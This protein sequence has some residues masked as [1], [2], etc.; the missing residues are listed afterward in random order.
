MKDKLPQSCKQCKYNHISIDMC[1]CDWH[2]K[3]SIDTTYY[4]KD[5]IPDYCPLNI[6]HIAKT[7]MR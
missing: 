7:Q 6:L 1:W 5:G 3:V 2:N 4:Q